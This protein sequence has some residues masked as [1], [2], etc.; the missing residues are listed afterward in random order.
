[1]TVQ[2]VIFLTQYLAKF[3]CI[4]DLSGIMDLLT[5]LFGEVRTWRV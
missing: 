5:T 1:L 3:P 2:K 4:T